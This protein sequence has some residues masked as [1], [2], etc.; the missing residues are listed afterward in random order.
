MGNALSK[1]IFAVI[2]TAQLTLMSPAQAQDQKIINQ[3][4]EGTCN[5]FLAPILGKKEIATLATERS[6]DAAVV[7]PCASKNVY[8]DPRL[9]SFV[10]MSD[11]TL[12]KATE[13]NAVRSY[14]IGRVLQSVLQ[15]FSQELDSTLK[16]SSA[17]K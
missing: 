14:V 15:C 10:A 7:C 16:A 8:S 17:V 1:R 11:E 2:I 5:S 4:V 9:S 6:I 3:L 13:P 12:L